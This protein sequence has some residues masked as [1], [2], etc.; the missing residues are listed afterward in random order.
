VVSSVLTTRSK[1]DLFRAAV[2]RA[3]EGDLVAAQDSLASGRPLGTRLV[4]AFDHWAGRYVGPA[5]DVPAVI[6]DNPDLLGEIVESAPR[7]F[8]ELV[9]EAI[10]QVTGP[11]AAEDIA[12]TLISTSVGLKHQVDSRDLYRVRI[13]VAVRLLVPRG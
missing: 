7:R 13:D 3:L 4:E 8:A 10:A 2:T 12:Q 9:T 6:D 1:H 11:R 5:R